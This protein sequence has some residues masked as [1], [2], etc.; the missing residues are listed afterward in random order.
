MAV[1]TLTLV[2]GGHKFV[3]RYSPGAERQLVDEIMRMVEDSPGVLDWL[4]AAT[5]S[6]Q[7]TSYASADCYDAMSPARAAED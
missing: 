7:I 4:D 2:K 1:R 3:F 6:F 5:L